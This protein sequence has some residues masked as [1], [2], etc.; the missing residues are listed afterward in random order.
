MK[1]DQKI[2]DD[3]TD[4]GIKASIVQV[5]LCVIANTAVLSSGMTL[6]FTAVALPYMLKPNDEFHITVDQASWVASIAAISTPLG[7]LVSGPLI[8]RLGRKKGLFLLNFPAFI[9]WLCVAINPSMT[10]LYIGRL[11]TGFACGLS[12]SPATVF[13]AESSIPSLRGYL[14]SGTS[15]AISMGVAIVY[16][17]GLIFKE[18]WKLTAGLCSIFPVC[19]AILIGFLM[20]ESPVWLMVNGKPDAACK[21]LKLLRGTNDISD[22]EHELDELSE[23]VNMNKKGKT[24]LMSTIKAMGKPESYKPLIIMNL[25]FFFQ[26]LTGVFVVIFYAVDVVREAGVTMD[27]FIVAVL[28]GITR[29][30]VTIFSAWMSRA[31]GRRPTAIISGVGMTVSLVTLATF[32][33]VTQSTHLSDTLFE[34]ESETNTT[35][36]SEFFNS[37]LETFKPGNSSE[38]ENAEIPSPS[39]LPVISILLYILASTV[40]FLTLPWAMI[41]E[42]Y[43]ARIRGVASGL[44][45][46][47][48]YLVSFVAVKLYPTMLTVLGKHGVFFFY[49]SM[50]FLGTIFVIFYLPETQGKTLA[51]IEKYFA[52]TKK[53]KSTAD[54]EEALHRTQLLTIRPANKENL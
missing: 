34:G 10:Q 14:V 38:L 9:G 20:P 25:F 30:G 45:T 11:L 40:G 44:T 36:L 46:C 23:R 48:T 3:E 47:I 8:D 15:I 27:P 54:E 53:K 22:I 13:S 41:G 35:N 29:L 52:G 49:G 21:S 2:S 5:V 31:Y 42:V 32:L 17:M 39:L 26:Q 24:N 51:E 6:G 33:Y 12:S 7:C 28:I 1:T 4:Y 18:N 43:P 50:A 19:S 16:I 37:T